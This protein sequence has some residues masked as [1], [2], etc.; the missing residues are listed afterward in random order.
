MTGSNPAG[1]Q[2]RG[3][4]ASEASDALPAT[5]WRGRFY[6]GTV[7]I[8]AGPSGSMKT[9]FAAMLAA[10]VSK[11]HGPVLWNNLEDAESVS[12][13][14][15]DAAGADLDKVRFADYRIP[16]DM[17]SLR[18]DVLAGGFKFLV[19]DTSAKCID[20]PIHKSVEKTARVLTPLTKL[21]DETGL[22]VLLVEHSLKHTRNLGTPMAAIPDGLLR[23][24]R[25]AILF[26]H[27]PEDVDR[28]AAAWVKDSWRELPPAIAFS[29][30]DS[31]EVD[32]PESD[33]GVRRIVALHVDDD[34]YRV[35]DPLALVRVMTGKGEGESAG[36]RAEAAQ[37]L[38]TKLATGPMPVNA[39]EMCPTHG[40]VKADPHAKGEDGHGGC[41]QP[42]I[43]VEGLTSLAEA[44]GVSWRTVRRAQ[45][46]IG[47]VL[48]RKGAGKGSVPWW[49]LPDGHP[50]LAPNAPTDLA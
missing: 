10:D 19:L 4:W 33:D 39:C 2:L 50:S 32:D 49:R 13:L 36:K 45:A 26:G 38:L 18:A 24:V 42:L 29:L 9:T 30:D 44:D 15:L 43:G 27:D 14:R 21:C 1:P 11:T 3:K 35:A 41:N 8:V 23:T 20:A 17:A 48:S 46:A 28:R 40:H 22:T 31:Y 34:K 16:H 37:W 6:E 12:R 47:I 7:A 25:T 5:F